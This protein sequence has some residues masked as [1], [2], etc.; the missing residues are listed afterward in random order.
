MSESV[1]ESVSQE[2]ISKWRCGGSGREGE[3]VSVCGEEKTG[4]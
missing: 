1:S 4:V 2:L 3:R